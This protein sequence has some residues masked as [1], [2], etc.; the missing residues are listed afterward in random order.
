MDVADVMSEV[1]DAL[2][3][4]SGLRVFRYP[5]DNA[6]PPAAI[7][8]YPEN[9]TF[10]ATYGRGMDRMTLPVVVVVGKVWDRST[11]DLIAA[12]AAGSGAE[13]VKAAIDGH[14][15]TACDVVRV[16][17][18][19]FDVMTIAGTD[20]IAALFDVDIAGQGSS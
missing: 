8:S 12:Y 1:G 6:T 13:S 19:E 20:F 10:D 15:Y 9:I 17:G 4:I 2:D 3:T 14:T 11:R 5:V 18:A 7:V 16:T